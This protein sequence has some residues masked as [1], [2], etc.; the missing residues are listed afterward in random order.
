[1]ANSVPPSRVAF[2]FILRAL[3]HRNYLLFFLGQGFS[4]IGTWM[5]Q[6]AMSWLVYRLT[7]SPFLL[8]L[9]GFAGMVPTFLLASFAGVLA[10]RWNRRHL[11]LVT[12]VLSM[13]QAGL[14]T[15]LTFFGHV[16]VG[17]LIALAVFLGIVNAGDIPARQALVVDIIE[18]QEDLGNAIALNSLMFNGARLIGPS[19]AG[20]VIAAVGEATCFLLNTLSFLAV[21]VA[22]IAIRTTRQQRTQ[23]EGVIGG[24]KEGY[25]YAFGFEPIR[26][27]LLLLALLSLVGM[28]FVVLMPVFA[29]DILGGGPHT[30]GFLMGASGIGALISALYLASRRTVLGLGNRIVLSTI[31]FSC[32][33]IAFSFSR[34]LALSLALMSVVGFGMITAMAASNT[35]IQTVVDEEKRG[36]VMSFYTMAF[37]GMAPFGSLLAGSVAH[38]IGAPLTVAFSG[39]ASIA[40][41]LLF[42]SK[43]PLIRRVVRPIYEERGIIR[44]L[45]TEL[46]TELQ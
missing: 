29:G 7:G 45:P 6:V 21:I 14:L 46:P 34:H 11:L 36:R 18:N 41:A 16:D 33:L 35:I 15:L 3:L 13:I 10:D 40:G 31:L 8:G 37:M 43:L 2:A 19:I 20:L 24:L 4:L 39:T 38:H 9:V 12:Q 22:L 5:Q 42:Y 17:H 27:I 23:T 25:R 28:P 44:E 32:A 26:Y 1:M 30:L